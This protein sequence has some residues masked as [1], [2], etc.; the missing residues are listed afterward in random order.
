VL[1]GVVKAAEATAPEALATAAHN[2]AGSGRA[3]EVLAGWLA[4]QELSPRDRFLARACLQAPLEALEDEAGAACAA[5]PSPR[6]GS[7]CPRC[8]GPPQLSIRAA[9]DD[10]LSRGHRQLSCVRCTHR[11][12]FSASS[13]PSCGESTGAKRTVYAEKHEG[14]VVSRATNGGSEIFAHLSIDACATCQRYLIDVDFGRDARAVPEVDELVALP[15]DL[16]AAEQGLSKV[17]PNLM[18]F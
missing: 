11:W 3:T 9:A 5:D 12:N 16:Y 15:L 10:A 13:C 7:N 18:G 14:P 17:T 4:G 8:G 1:P 2:L 6:G